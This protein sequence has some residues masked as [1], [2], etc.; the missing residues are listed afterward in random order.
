MDLDFSVI[1][2]FWAT[3]KHSDIPEL[4]VRNSGASNATST[5]SVRAKTPPS[6]HGREDG[7]AGLEVLVERCCMFYV[8]RLQNTNE[9]STHPLTCAQSLAGN[10]FRM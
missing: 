6:D 2:P 5:T 8:V 9:F 7:T 3:D 10:R 1:Q 4:S